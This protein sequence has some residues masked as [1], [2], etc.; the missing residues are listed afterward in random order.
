MNLYKN[1][2]LII[3]KFKYRRIQEVRIE[4]YTTKKVNGVYS[5]KN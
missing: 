1:Y 5:V 2:T 3:K 4:I